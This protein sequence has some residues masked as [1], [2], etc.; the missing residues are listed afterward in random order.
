MATGK[1]GIEIDKGPYLYSC[2]Q[3]TSDLSLPSEQKQSITNLEV[4]ALKNEI[5]G[6][7]MMV[8]APERKLV[9]SI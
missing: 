8:V 3:N 1:T 4:I 2:S 6:S 7:A 5:Y 9:S